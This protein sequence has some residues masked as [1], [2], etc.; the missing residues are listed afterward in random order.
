MPQPSSL[1]LIRLR[2][3]SRSVTS[4]RVAPAS[5]A[6]STS[7]FTA[8]AGRSITSPAAMRLTT[9]GGRTRIGMIRESYQDRAAITS[10]GR[11][12]AARACAA[13]S[14]QRRRRGLRA[15]HALGLADDDEGEG[16]GIEQA[17]GHALHVVEGDG[18]D[19]AVALGEIVGREV[20]ELH[21][22]QRVGD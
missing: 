19:I 9:V 3:P 13:R 22:D 14:E 4:M 10:A 8:D 21:A 5:M 17:L 7:S 6:F 1:T 16:I 2:P 12:P 20:L 18:V 15:G 11:W